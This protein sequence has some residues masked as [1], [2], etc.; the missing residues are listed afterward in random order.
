MKIFD[1]WAEW[2]P[3]CKKFGPIFEKVAKEFPDIEFVKVDADTENGSEFL[4]LY[5]IRGIPTILL[6]DNENSVLFQHAGILSEANL[7][8]LVQFHKTQIANSK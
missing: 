8:N 2:C 4:N 6:L 5:G 7:R 3:P 1:V